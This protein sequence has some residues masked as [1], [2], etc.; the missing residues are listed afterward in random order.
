M[1]TTLTLI[2]LIIGASALSF[3]APLTGSAATQGKQPKSRK[4]NIIFVLADDLGYGDLSCYGQKRFTTPNLDHLAAEGMRFTQVYAGSTVCAPSRCTLMTG[5]HTGHALVRGNKANGGLPLRPEDVTVAELLK[6]ANYVTGAFGKWGLGIEG[7]TGHPNQQGFDE[8]FGYLDQTHAHFYYTDHLY[9]NS[10]KVAFNEKPYSHD[11]IVDSA[12]DFIRKNK[13]QPFFL[14]FSLTIP[15]ASLEVPDDSLKKYLGKYPEQPFPGGHYTKQETPRAAFAAMIDRLDQAVGRMMALLK[16]LGM[17]EDTI[18]FF[19]SDNGP[20]QEGGGDPVFF[21]SSGALRGIKRDLYEG[22]IRVPMI[23][24]WPG[25]IKAGAVSNQVWAFWDFLPTAAAIAGVQAAKNMDGISMLPVLLGK[26]Q[27]NHEYVYWEFF[28]GG[29]QQ[30][31]RFKNW[32]GIRRE[33]GKPVELFNLDADIGEQDNIAAKHPDVVARIEKLLK[34]AR[35]ESATWPVKT[36][37]EKK[38]R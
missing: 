34:Q 32:K 11:L 10:E 25:K 30:A 13:D 12:F 4:P 33:A 29:F 36:D 1:K 27:R 18:V 8:W 3:P 37:G 21:N 2:L 26:P 23:A 5:F 15:H 35:T 6:Q 19:T 31:I 9:K 24:R 7:T 22:G 17:D 38:N 16:E 20:H 14:Y 28:E